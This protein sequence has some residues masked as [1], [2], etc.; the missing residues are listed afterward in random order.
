MIFIYF[1]AACLAR[2][3]SRGCLLSP[4][5]IDQA[6]RFINTIQIL[7]DGNIPRVYNSAILKTPFYRPGQRSKKQ[8]SRKDGTY[9]ATPS[10]GAPGKFSLLMLHPSLASKTHRLTECKI[11]F[12]ALVLGLSIELVK[13]QVFGKAPA[14]SSFNAFNGAVSHLSN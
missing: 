7:C 4:Y 9:Y 8:S 14:S 5:P 10:A 2:R 12:C 6:N 1:G 13:G 3:L 11:A